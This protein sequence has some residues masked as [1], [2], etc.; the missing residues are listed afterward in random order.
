MQHSSSSP[1]TWLLEFMQR[2]YPETLHALAEQLLAQVRTHPSVQDAGLWLRDLSGR[3]Y[4]LV[5]LQRGDEHLDDRIRQVIARGQAQSVAL[6]AATE[7]V[8]PL[9]VGDQ[10]FGALVIVER[11]GST[12]RELWQAAAAHMAVL[13]RLA[14]SASPDG[15]SENEWDEF[16]SHA[17]HEI[18]NPLASA[19]GYAD[20]LLRRAKKEENESYS[21]GLLVISQQLTK[22][23]VLLDQMSDTSRIA[24]NRLQLQHSPADLAELVRRAV[25]NQQIKTEQHSIQIEGADERLPVDLDE[26]RIAQVIEAM[27]A[28]AVRFSPNGSVISVRLERANAVNGTLLARIVVADQGIGVPAGEEAR[29]F[30]RFKRGSNVAGMYSGLGLGLF[31][32]SEIAARHGGRMWLESA[33]EQGSTCYFEL[34]IAA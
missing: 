7:Q 33:P 13:L 29:I 18:K 24:T 12:D 2:S 20:L 32:A 8:I 14:Q 23:T 3:M 16:I 4:K 11:P 6:P 19:K 27:I 10:V 26:G 1:L 9:C 22:A 28:N 5:P 31:V 15:E 34:P 17:V 30:Q 21:K 25:Q